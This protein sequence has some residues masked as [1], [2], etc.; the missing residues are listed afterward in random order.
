MK[1]LAKATTRVIP[2]EEFRSSTAPEKCVSGD[3]PAKMEVVWAK[4]Y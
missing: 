4:A 2:D 1:D 3:G